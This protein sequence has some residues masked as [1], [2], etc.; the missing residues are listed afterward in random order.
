MKTTI[1][2]VAATLAVALAGTLFAVGR[3][4]AGCTMPDA[5][6]SP[7]DLQMSLF[8]GPIGLRPAS[9]VRFADQAGNDLTA[10]WINV[11]WDSSSHSAAIVG[12]WRVSFLAK[13]NQGIPDGAPIDEGYVTWHGDG[14]ELM[15]SGRPP[16]TGSFCMGVWKQV[17]PATYK[18]NHVALSWDPT[19]TVFVGPAS[20]RE[21]VTVDRSGNHYSG[22][23]TLIQ[24][25]LDE[26]TELAHITGIIRA[27]RVTVN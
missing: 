2:S 22:T 11:D 18:L 16:M 25:S 26:T 9:L 3:A 20:I 5:D 27:T 12:L 10:R 15:N 23:F 19:G 13:G 24:Y 4:S 1:G 7:S 8:H 21:T 14:T 17:G 6:A